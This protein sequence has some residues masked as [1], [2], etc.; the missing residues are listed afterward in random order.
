MRVALLKPDHGAAGGFE[1]LL[2][3]LHRSLTEAGC[4]TQ[5]VGFDALAP[6]PRCFG[7]PVSPGVRQ[8]H[9][10]YFQYLDN[11][12]R[13]DRL[14]LDDFDVVVSTQPPTYLAPHDRIVAVTYHQ[15]RV[16]YDLAE[17]V[18]DAGI[19]DAGIHDAAVTEV[20][21]IDGVRLDGVRRWLSGSDEVTS[22]LQRF[23]DVRDDVRRLRAAPDA[24]AHPAPPYDPGGPAVCVSR[25][26]WT[27]RTEL[28]VQAAHLCPSARFELVG[29]GDR[30]PWLRFLDAR[31][32]RDPDEA[33]AAGALQTW[34]N[35]GAR[36]LG[37]WRRRRPPGPGA[38]NLLVHGEAPDDVR[39]AAYDRAGVVVAPAHREDYGLTVLE[40]FAR[41]RPV[42]VCDDGGG[43]VELVRG[44]G[45]GLVVE[46]TGEAIGRAVERLRADPG[47][48]RRL[49]EAAAA[50]RGPDPGEAVAT[51]LGAIE[52]VAS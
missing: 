5:V 26:A 20:R 11:V 27:K 42:I 13:V 43:L 21:R 40:A 6:A 22:R 25:H 49:A 10:E 51:L 46:P 39:D 34:L 4:T 30:L 14:R 28:V 32:R 37:P 19:V 45:A 8:E 7:V 52:D 38:A 41:G 50:H 16:F 3:G 15:A 44:T 18:V 2:A 31:F 48:A 17:A 1:R 24:P 12:E 29:G 33:R 23:W 9:P 36:V 35:P 47:E